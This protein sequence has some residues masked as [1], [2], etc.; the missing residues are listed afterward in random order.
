MIRAFASVA[1]LSAIVIQ[2]PAGTLAVAG[3]V[4]TPLTL[5]AADLKGLPRTSVTVTEQNR[6]VKYEGVFVS[7]VLR[8][9]GVPLGKDLS[10]PAV[11]IYVLATAKDGYQVVFSLGELDQDLT[12]SEIIVADLVDGKPLSE[13]QG[14]FRIVAPHDS[15][16]ARAIRMLQRLDV[17]K[18]RK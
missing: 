7:E 13:T 5:S 9:A 2:A 16:A 10:G 18:L 15:K 4:S 14:P 1:L 8:R 12:H 3:D 11:A 6:Q 17:V